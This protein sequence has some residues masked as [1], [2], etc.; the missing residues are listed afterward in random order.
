[1]VTH[2]QILSTLDRRTLPTVIQRDIEV[3]QVKITSICS[4]L[5]LPLRQSVRL[6]GLHRLVSEYLAE[7]GTVR[8]ERTSWC[9]NFSQPNLRTFFLNNT[10]KFSSQVFVQFFFFFYIYDFWN[11][12][13]VR[14]VSNSLLYRIGLNY[15][16]FLPPVCRMKSILSNTLVPHYSIGQLPLLVDIMRTFS[17]VNP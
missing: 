7:C 3:G 11:K 14:I 8:L 15:V 1:M 6:L 2:W 12:N 16:Q 10:H 4:Y 5:Y 9:S 17:C 13:F